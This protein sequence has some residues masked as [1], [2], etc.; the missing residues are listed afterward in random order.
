VTRP[1]RLDFHASSKALLRQPGGFEG[2]GSTCE[3][4]AMDDLPVAKGPD[5]PDVPADLH[6][7]LPSTPAKGHRRDDLVVSV[8]QLVNLGAGVIELIQ[9][10]SREL[11][12][13]LRSPSERGGS[14]SAPVATYSKVGDMSAIPASG[15]PRLK[16]S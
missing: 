4:L 7:A 5:V 9:H 8:C 14:G 3:S 15:S 11:G 13:S 2:L 10:P 12:V 1:E 6:A 16:A